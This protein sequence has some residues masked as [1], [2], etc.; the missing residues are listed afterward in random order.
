MT[1]KLLT[2]SEF[3]QLISDNTFRQVSWVCG[4]W[5][6]WRRPV[7]RDR[8]VYQFANPLGC[9]HIHASGH[10]SRCYVAAER[11][12]FVERRA[13]AERHGAGFPTAAGGTTIELANGMQ[14]VMAGILLPMRGFTTA[15]DNDAVP[16]AFSAFGQRDRRG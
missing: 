10:S 5:V 13:V 16:Q 6:L 8:I 2:D 14:K 9:D 11:L 1:D 15:G 3:M 7:R 4:N 12:G